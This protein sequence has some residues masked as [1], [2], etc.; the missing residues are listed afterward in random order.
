MR[1]RQRFRIVAILGLVVGAA[2]VAMAQPD[3]NI[4]GKAAN[5]PNR[6]KGVK[7]LRALRNQLT[8]E[9]LAILGQRLA[10]KD[11]AQ[12][13]EMYGQKLTEAQKKAIVQS[14]T[15]R[16]QAVLA[17]QQKHRENVAK[18]LGVTVEDLVTKEQAYALLHKGQGLKADAAVNKQVLRGAGP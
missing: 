14:E 4:T 5:P 1:A 12:L 16:Y 7:R 17:A 10:Q 9:R 13:E 8:P 3:P 6:Q 2:A 15:E 11:I 18:A